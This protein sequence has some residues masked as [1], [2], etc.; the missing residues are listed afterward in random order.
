MSYADLGQALGTDNPCLLNSL[1]QGFRTQRAMVQQATIHREKR[2]N[3]WIGPFESAP[4]S[5]A[6]ARAAGH[7]LQKGLASVR[8]SASD[9]LNIQARSAVGVTPPVGQ[10]HV[11]DQGK[12]KR[13]KRR[14]NGVGQG[15][16]DDRMLP[17]IKARLETCS[18][19]GSI[20]LGVWRLLEPFCGRWVQ[21]ST[22]IEMS[23]TK[24]DVLTVE[25]HGGTGAKREGATGMTVE[26]SKES[27]DGRVGFQCALD[28]TTYSDF[29]IV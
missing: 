23:E 7:E 2:K 24:K 20:H 19:R 9:T 6:A 12:L 16:L 25:R 29:D 13:R 4:D 3:R 1:S 5:T 22:G 10:V 14:G 17:G 26:Q 18:N 28:A 15:V 21:S 27:V 8:V 11:G